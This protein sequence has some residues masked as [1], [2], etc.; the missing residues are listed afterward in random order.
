MKVWEFEAFFTTRPSRGYWVFPK[1]TQSRAKVGDALYLRVTQANGRP[2]IYGRFEITGK[3]VDEVPGEHWRPG[4]RPMGLCPIV[5]FKVQSYF[6]A[7]RLTP[8]E[9]QLAGLLPTDKT[10]RVPQ[11]MAAEITDREAQVIDGL[12]GRRGLWKP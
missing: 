4:K 8:E 6:P 5:D 1:T 12:L 11:Q 10:L 3:R 7:N 2:G 9:L